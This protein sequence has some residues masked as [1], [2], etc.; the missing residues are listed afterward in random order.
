MVLIISIFILDFSKGV[1]LGFNK[2]NV[3]IFSNITK[4]LYDIAHVRFIL[5]YY[6][7]FISKSTFIY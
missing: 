7:F 2:A 4:F 6:F 5:T 3:C 1:K